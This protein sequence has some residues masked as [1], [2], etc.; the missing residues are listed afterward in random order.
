MRQVILGIEQLKAL[1]PSWLHK[2]R[3]GLLCNQASVDATLRPSR[4]IVA[5]LAGK[6][7]RAL[8]SPQHGITGDA[9]A[10]MIETEDSVDPDLAIPVYSLYSAKTRTPTEEQLAK[11]DCLLIDL[12]D[13]GTRVYT[14]ATTMG[15]CLE[16]AARYKKKVV[17]LD[18]PNPINAEQVEGN[19]LKEGLRSFVGFAPMP[20]RHAMTMGELA[21]FFNKERQIGADLE[22]IPMQGYKR[23]YFFS[24]TGLPWV[25]PSPNM[26]S[27]ATALVYPG[28][29]LL[30]GTNC[31]EGRGAARPFELFGAPFIEAGLL[32]KKLEKRK[33]AGCFFV[34]TSFTPSFDKWQGEL[35][36]GLE[37]QITDARVYKPYY[38]T[39]AIIQE[40]ITAWP[41]SFSWLPPPYE[42]EFEKLPIDIISGD[43][44]IRKGLEARR[45]LEEMEASWQEDLVGFLAKRKQ[46]LLY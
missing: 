12:Q 33:L 44:A 1:Q 4:D 30:E 8:F 28:Q 17:V 35:C 10:N 38:T 13:V 7:L 32:R 43:E 5:E 18:R 11:I 40:L 2:A 26:L 19:I 29:V 36:H 21:R 39:L 6:N 25:P 42:Y 15:L 14:F 16:A 41:D 22:I 27:P 23:E 9:Q 34:E 31:S 3:L 20:M 24:D 46:Y 45:N 37:I